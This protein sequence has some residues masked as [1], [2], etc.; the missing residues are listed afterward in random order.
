MFVDDSRSFTRGMVCTPSYQ[1]IGHAPGHEWHVSYCIILHYCVS[2]FTIFTGKTLRSRQREAAHL[3]SE[4]LAHCFSGLV[5]AYGRGPLQSAGI[6]SGSSL[7]SRFFVFCIFL[8]SLCRHFFIFFD[9]DFTSVI[10]KVLLLLWFEESRAHHG[11]AL[12][13]VPGTVPTL[14]GDREFLATAQSQWCLL[15]TWHWWFRMILAKRRHLWISMA[16]WVFDRE[17][18]Y[19]ELWFLTWAVVF[20]EVLNQAPRATSTTKCLL[21][22]EDSDKAATE[23]RYVLL[24]TFDLLLSVQD[25]RKCL[26]CLSWPQ[27]LTQDDSGI[28]A[29]LWLWFSTA[30]HPYWRS[31]GARQRAVFGKQAFWH[32]RREVERKAPLDLRR[33]Y[34]APYN[35]CWRGPWHPRCQ[36]GV[37]YKISMHLHFSRS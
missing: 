8:H 12:P 27:L 13:P 5:D 26:P 36:V 6:V 3:V 2:S 24:N 37:A 22:S 7:C 17:M 1:Q 35:S 11:F 21:V 30:W 9:I 29:L 32:Y 18:F 23:L 25:V 14:R 20:S 15:T 16:S 10:L 31:E 33:D 34:L 28:I 4:V 19:R